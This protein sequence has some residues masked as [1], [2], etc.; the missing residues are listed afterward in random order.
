MCLHLIT[1][2]LFQQKTG[3][4][5]HIPGKLVPVV[6]AYLS[7]EL[8]TAVYAK[9]LESQRLVSEQLR[10]TVEDAVNDSPPNIEDP[11]LDLLLTEL[12]EMVLVKPRK[13]D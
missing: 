8:D 10:S 1:V 13:T 7:K 5:V 6:I 2:V 9:L 3:C 12:K 11:A 4:I